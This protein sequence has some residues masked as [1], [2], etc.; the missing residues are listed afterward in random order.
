MNMQAAAADFEAFQDSMEQYC[1]L[2]LDGMCDQAVDEQAASVLLDLAHDC[3]EP[4][5]DL[6]L[7]AL[8]DQAMDE[9][10]ASVLLDL[11]YDCGALGGDSRTPRCSWPE[12]E[13][14]HVNMETL[15]D[16][17]PEVDI[18]LLCDG[19]LVGEHDRL[20]GYL[21]ASA[22]KELEEHPQRLIT[23]SAKKLSCTSLQEW[24]VQRVRKTV[25]EYMMW[26]I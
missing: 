21:S 9:Q 3:E 1:D 23:E 7:D 16:W 13:I 22:L 14:P 17:V 11:E 20:Y 8:C 4:D 2:A 6:A 25:S 5:C 19:A 15:R 24:L 12:L 26:V 10:A 18:G